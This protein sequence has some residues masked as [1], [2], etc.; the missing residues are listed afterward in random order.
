MNYRRQ[1]VKCSVTEFNK[2]LK[3]A[4]KARRYVII[5]RKPNEGETISLYVYLWKAFSY[6]YMIANKDGVVKRYE[7]NLAVDSV[8]E[9]ATT[10]TGF[11]AYSILQRYYKIPDMDDEYFSYGIKPYRNKKYIGKRVSNCIGYDMNSAFS[12]GMLQPLPDTTKPLGT[13]IVES[14]MYGFDF[15]GNRVKTGKTAMFRFYLMDSPYKKFVEKWYGKK[16]NP[17]TEQEKKDAKF[18]LNAAIGAIQRHNC[19][20]R[21]AILDNFNDFM[22]Y[23]INKYK[24]IIVSSN[25]DSIVATERIP[26]LDERLGSEIGQFKIEHT[27]DFAIAKNGMSTQWNLEIPAFGAGKPKHWFKTFEKINHRPFDILQDEPP[28]LGN[29]YELNED[30]MQ[31]E[32][33]NYDD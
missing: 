11:D 7:C 2:M 18:V 15:F 8:D 5:R 19:F 4:Y 17:K 12:Y 22:Q 10:K 20:M 9:K 16:K 23:I 3:W 21:A 28:V 6:I 32:E 14:N 25:T 33:V 27:G 1:V 24:D 13:G 30:T 31:L 26:E 29:G